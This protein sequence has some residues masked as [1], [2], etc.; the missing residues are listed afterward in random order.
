L[1]MCATSASGEKNQNGV[2]LGT[3]P[4]FIVKQMSTDLRGR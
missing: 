3:L 2:K 4:W 1:A